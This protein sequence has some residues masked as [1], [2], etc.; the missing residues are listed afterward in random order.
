MSKKVLHLVVDPLCVWTYAANPLFKPLSDI[1]DLVVEVHCVGLYAGTSRRQLTPE[2]RSHLES[3][4]WAAR[5]LLGVEMDTD[6][7]HVLMK[8]S[9]VVLDSF[10]SIRAVLAER[11][12]GGSGL[13]TLLEIQA[14]QYLQ[15][16][17]VSRAEVVQ[18]VLSRGKNLELSQS[19]NQLSDQEVN[20]YI[21]S[22]KDFLEKN[23]GMNF[24]AV[25]L[26]EENSLPMNI[27]VCGYIG[28]TENWLNV[29]KHCLD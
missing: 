7:T 8:D 1:E 18:K 12:L 20:D 21:D 14:A 9:S 24:P 28:Y 15:G 5:K 4:H 27:D 22:S 10:Q 16:M 25:V 26:K 3:S 6:Y 23:Q 17:D 13:N 11:R 29:I 2:W 19:F